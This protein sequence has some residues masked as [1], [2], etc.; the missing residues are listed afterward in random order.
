MKSYL[1]IQA[2]TAFMTFVFAT[3]AINIWERFDNKIGKTVSISFWIYAI[4]TGIYYCCDVLVFNNMV[5]ESSCLK[6][7]FFVMAIVIY[8][9]AIC[10]PT[11]EQPDNRKIIGGYTLIVLLVLIGVALALFHSAD[12]QAYVIEQTPKEAHN[13]YEL[14]SANISSEIEG[15]INGS[16]QGSYFVIYGTADG[17]INGQIQQ[18]DVYKFFYIANSNTGEMR[19]MTLDARNTPL[20]YVE[21]GETPYLL[22]KV[23]TPYSIDYNVDPPK[24]CDYGEKTVKY[25]L[26]I[27]KGAIFQTFETVTN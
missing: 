5:F 19:T 2:V 16:M 8:F 10:M 13:K 12:Y 22:E 17:A 21:E 26:Y 4:A 15:S 20:Y 3:I 7:G 25:E 27:P 11:G 24:E 1:I 9:L 23:Y 6:I 18:N 14:L